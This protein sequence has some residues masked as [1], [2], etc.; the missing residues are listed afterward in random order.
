VSGACTLGPSPQKLCSLSSPIMGARAPG[1]RQVRLP[2]SDSAAVPVAPH[3]HPVALA[4]TTGPS[5][6]RRRMGASGLVSVDGSGRLNDPARPKVR[7]F[8]T[9]R[10]PRLPYSQTLAGRKQRWGPSS[11]DSRES[12]SDLAPEA[13]QRQHRPRYPASSD[14]ARRS[15]DLRFH[16]ARLPASSA[17]QRSHRRGQPSPG[18]DRTR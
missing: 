9:T 7:T 3:E 1:I 10:L 5:Q 8:T 2:P 16:P 14:G 13:S 12:L 11:T 6:L 18:R 4:S 17:H 15:R